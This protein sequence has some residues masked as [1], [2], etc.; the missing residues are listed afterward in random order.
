MH[1]VLLMRREVSV[2]ERAWARFNW[3]GIDHESQLP[4][5]FANKGFYGV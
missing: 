1:L 4:I 5:A 3:N 2:I